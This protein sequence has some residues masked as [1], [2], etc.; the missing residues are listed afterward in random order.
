MLLASGSTDKTVKL[1]NFPEGELLRTLPNTD[2]IQSVAFSPDSKT[3]AIGSENG[4]IKIWWLDNG[5]N[6]TL[7]GHSGP[8]KSVAFSPDG[9][10]LASGSAD[11]TVKLWQ[12]TNG[13]VLHTLTGHSGPVLSV[14]FSPEGQ[15]LASGSYDKTIKLWNLKT[16]ELMTNFAEHS[17]PVW[18]VAFSSQD[19]VL[20]SGS[21][22]ETIKLWPVPVP[23]ATQ[24]NSPA[25]E[26]E[27]TPSEII[28]PGEIAQ[29]NRKLYDQ[30][31]NSWRSTPSFNT[32]LVYRVTVNEEGVITDYQ[33]LNQAAGDFI[34]EV[35]L[36][37]FR[38]VAPQS[39]HF[40]QFKV[41][42]KPS[43]VI[44]VSPWEGWNYSY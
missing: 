38:K 3:L 26:V 44:E 34:Q 42:F 23:L 36:S 15:A 6:Y 37:S 7:T 5:G 18:S 24:V 22:D 21:A 33:P 4:T 39:N 28:S 19:T 30:I 14:A 35:S 27:A 2:W 8:V 32:S 40:S 13:K 1:W 43:G 10:T 41:V 9:K 17:K 20:A 25:P 11:K 29:L 16:G 31:D 12:F